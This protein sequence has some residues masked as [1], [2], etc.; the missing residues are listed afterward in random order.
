MKSFEYTKENL[1]RFVEPILNISSKVKI[2]MTNSS[3]VARSQV[4][5]VKTT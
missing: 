2:Y 3:G 5:G 1:L 4:F